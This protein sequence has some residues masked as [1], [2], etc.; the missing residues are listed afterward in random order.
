MMKRF[1]PLTFAIALLLAMATA[2]YAI[3][4][5]VDGV[6]EATWDLGAPGQ[7]PGSAL[8]NNEVDVPDDSD[9]AE[10]KWTNDQNNLYILVDTVASP[11]QNSSSTLLIC[12]DS[13]ADPST[14]SDTTSNWY[15]QCNSV[16]G[17]DIHVRVEKVLGTYQVVKY[18]QNGDNG[19]L[20]PGAS[21]AFGDVL[22][23]SIPLS[24][25]FG[26]S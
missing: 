12:I 22:E 6:K 20:I 23:V 21:H 10:I 19:Q 4:I 8:D 3:T 26:Q 18:D 17:F 25:I 24:E 7:T 9:I 5:V 14:G 2:V 13:D 16:T 11:V 15:T 1:V